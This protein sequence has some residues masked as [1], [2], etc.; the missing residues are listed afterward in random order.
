MQKV[1]LEEVNG[2]VVLALPP[3]VLKRLRLRAGS[4]VELDVDVDTL[5][6]VKSGTKSHPTLDELIAMSDPAAFERTPED[7]E[8]L[9]S[10]PVGRELL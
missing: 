8:W 10:P 6:L 9:N 1:Q 5:L 2:T 7:L 4:E 3:S